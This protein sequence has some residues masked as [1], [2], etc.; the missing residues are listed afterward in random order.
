MNL[1]VFS[2]ERDVQETEPSIYILE[3]KMVQ[4]KLKNAN[5]KTTAI[6]CMRASSTFSTVN[7]KKISI[8]SKGHQETESL[9]ASALDFWHSTTK[10]AGDGG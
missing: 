7:K 8:D 10:N 9:S 3:M 2:K 4:Q 5:S 6:C 1:P